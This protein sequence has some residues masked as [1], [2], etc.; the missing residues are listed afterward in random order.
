MWLLC[1]LP[2]MSQVRPP[3][4]SECGSGSTAFEAPPGVQVGVL[5]T[6]R[7]RWGAKGGLSRR[8]RCASCLCRRDAE[9]T[10]NRTAGARELRASSPGGLCQRQGPRAHDPPGQ[11]V[12][13][14][15]GRASAEVGAGGRRSG[16]SGSQPGASLVWVEARRPGEHSVSPRVP[17]QAE[18]G[19]RG[20]LGAPEDS[21]DPLAKAAGAVLSGGGARV[22]GARGLVPVTSS[23]SPRG[24]DAITAPSWPGHS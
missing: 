3:G 6:H 5:R 12:T 24:P 9:A 8:P 7:G 18:A 22:Q 16:P 1:R 23:S 13:E 2:E 21:P 10:G 15:E 4:G 11:G 20:G 17:R 14:T 19:C